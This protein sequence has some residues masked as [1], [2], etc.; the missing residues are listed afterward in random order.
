MR[1]TTPW[2]SQLKSLLIIRDASPMSFSPVTIP[3]ENIRV[4]Y[5]EPSFPAHARLLGSPI[6]IW[7]ESIRKKYE[8]NTNSSDSHISRTWST[9]VGFAY[10]WESDA[11]HFRGGGGLLIR[12]TLTSLFNLN[13]INY[14]AGRRRRGQMDKGSTNLCRNIA[15]NYSLL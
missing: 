3:V 11:I 5:T 9:K 4:V 8:K 10:S 7:A 2:L 13:W 14:F 12:L 15:R 6:F 1:T